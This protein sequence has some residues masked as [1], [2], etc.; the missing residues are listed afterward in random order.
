MVNLN[1]QMDYILYQNVYFKK[2]GEKINNPAIKIYVN[3]IKNTII[4][5]IKTRYR[6]ELLAPERL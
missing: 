6:R 2:H 1:Y 3:K 5:K 4:F